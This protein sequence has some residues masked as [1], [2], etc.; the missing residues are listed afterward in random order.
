MS[1]SCVWIEELVFKLP[2]LKQYVARHIANRANSQCRRLVQAHE[3]K[4]SDTA[5]RLLSQAADRLR[6]AL[7]QLNGPNDA[8]LD[9]D[10]TGRTRLQQRA[11]AL[12]GQVEQ[13]YRR[14]SDI[15]HSLI[16]DANSADGL[17]LAAQCRSEGL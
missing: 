6:T 17:A 13:W 5:V 14:Q 1:T 9:D 15:D 3:K 4:H 8:A 10:L 2:P 12:I 16:D 7:K 11:S